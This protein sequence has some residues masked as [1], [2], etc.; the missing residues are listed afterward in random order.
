MW[1]MG[2][3]SRD[4]DGFDE[5]RFQ[6]VVDGTGK[7]VLTHGRAVLKGLEGKGE[8]RSKL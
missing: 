2:N 4:E 8:G 7:K 1:R 3:N 6:T 5:I